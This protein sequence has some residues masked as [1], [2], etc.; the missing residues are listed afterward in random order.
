MPPTEPAGTVL[1]HP[2]LQ[3]GKELVGGNEG[4]LRKMVTPPPLLRE[5]SGDPTPPK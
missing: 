1:L 3:M 4:G 5:Q 2:T